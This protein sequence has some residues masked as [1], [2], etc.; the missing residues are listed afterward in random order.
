MSES[1]LQ[2]LNRMFGERGDSPLVDMEIYGFIH[3][4]MI[5]EVFR[6]SC[7]QQP[8]PIRQLFED[9]IRNVEEPLPE[10]TPHDEFPGIN[11]TPQFYRYENSDYEY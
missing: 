1:L 9:V 3:K 4:H 7:L 11:S 5:E 8:T 2:K 6:Q 10:R